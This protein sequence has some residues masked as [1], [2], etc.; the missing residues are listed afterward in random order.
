MNLYY[1]HWR[2]TN[3]LARPPK[4][5]YMFF[6]RLAPMT[7]SI[8][9]THIY[10]KIRS[11]RNVKLAIW[12]DPIRWKI[13]LQVYVDTLVVEPLL[14]YLAIRYESIWCLCEARESG[15]RYQRVDSSQSQYKLPTRDWLSSLK[16]VAALKSNRH[17]VV[18]SCT[19]KYLR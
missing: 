13:K 8:I 1:V 19:C 4:F 14:T 12:T 9:I 10:S 15:V 2:R 11:K 7:M 17:I 16:F 3:F 6:Q 5:E 18:I